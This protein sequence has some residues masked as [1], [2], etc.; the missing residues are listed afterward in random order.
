MQPKIRRIS[1]I[2]LLTVATLAGAAGLSVGYWHLLDLELSGYRGIKDFELERNDERERLRR[3]IPG[4]PA[5]RERVVAEKFGDL[6]EAADIRTDLR[7]VKI[8]QYEL[9]GLFGAFALGAL[10][11]VFAWRRKH[12]VRRAVV[13]AIALAG[14]SQ[15]LPMLLLPPETLKIFYRYGMWVVLGAALLLLVEVA[16]DRLAGRRANPTQTEAR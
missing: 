7:F 16:L 11:Y 4:V 2:G 6:P 14:V 12:P 8:W 15:A 13:A 9:A 3:M 10:A 5:T 1:I